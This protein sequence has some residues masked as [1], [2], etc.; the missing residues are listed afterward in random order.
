MTDEPARTSRQ[1]NLI[2]ATLAFVVWGGWAWYVNQ[3]RDAPEALSPIGS[4]LI[5]GT[6]SCLV[7]LFMLRSVTTLFHL[8]APHPARF[9]LPAV[10][11]TGLTGSC[12][13]MAHIFAGTANVAGTVIPGIVVAL[14][15]NTLTCWKLHQQTA[16]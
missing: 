13:S 4:G 11:T 14:C 15:F 9:F 16:A 8:F 12:I 6:A 7:T 3:L 1:Y 5:Q 10:L 2:S